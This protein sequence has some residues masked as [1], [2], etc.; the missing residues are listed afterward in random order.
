MR[1]ML[2]EGM[3]R[4]GILR[5]GM[6]RV[7]TEVLTTVVL[8]PCAFLAGELRIRRGDRAALLRNL[9]D[10]SFVFSPAWWLL[11]FSGFSAG[12]SAKPRLLRSPL[13][14]A[15]ARMSLAASFGSSD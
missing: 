8:R 6:R 13:A 9:A 1:G 12:F 11:A 15:R 10:F 4:A 2:R 7:R 5:A 3:L 14:A